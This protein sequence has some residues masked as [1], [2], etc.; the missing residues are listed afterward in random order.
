[1]GLLTIAVFMII[2][3]YS[4]SHAADTVT[5]TKKVYMDVAIGGNKVSSVI[6]NS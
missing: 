5:V 6:T 3:A 1:M 4:F 2:T